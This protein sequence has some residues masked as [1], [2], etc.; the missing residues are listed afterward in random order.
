MFFEI[1]FGEPVALPVPA[2]GHS[3][4]FGL[5]LFVPVRPLANNQLPPPLP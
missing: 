4:H 3:C 5:G 1:E 2:F